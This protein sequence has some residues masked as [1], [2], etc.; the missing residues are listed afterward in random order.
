MPGEVPGPDDAR[1]A[2]GDGTPTPVP[3]DVAPVPEDVTPVPEDVAPVPDDVAPVPEDVAPVP[4]DVAPVPDDVEAVAA[5]VGLGSRPPHLGDP[6]ARVLLV[7]HGVT[8]FTAEGRLDGRGGPDPSLNTAGRAQAAAAGQLV[9]ALVRSGP[10]RVVTSSLARAVQTGSVVA[11]ALG[12]DASVDADWDEQ[13]FGEWDGRTFRELVDGEP[14][15]MR[16]LRTDAGYRP[17][18]GETHDELVA[19]VLPAWG[20]VVATGGTTVVVCHRKPILVVLAELLGLAH[21][22]AW[23]LA[24]AP[25][26]LTAVEV[27]DDGEVSVLFT[28]RT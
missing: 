9:A 10:A 23:R 13:S 4:V 18:G 8:D 12:V 22:R 27:W 26:S 3:D 16:A 14:D 2:S 15:G 20:R 28:N 5:R 11:T 21:E 7:R 19:R 17:P 1:P 25:G 6:A 24:A